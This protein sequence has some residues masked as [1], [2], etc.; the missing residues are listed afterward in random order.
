MPSLAIESLPWDVDLRF[1]SSGLSSKTKI[2]GIS[3]AH[4]SL[5]GEEQ[6]AEKRSR[7]Q[8]GEE[9]EWE[10]GRPRLLLRFPEVTAPLTSAPPKDAMGSPLNC[11]L[12]RQGLAGSPH[13]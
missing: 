3:D 7:N 5:L 10:V 4:F 2:S 9:Q 12:I 13:M 8:A 1:I 6:G 11:I